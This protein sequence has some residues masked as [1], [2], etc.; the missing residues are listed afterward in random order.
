MIEQTAR[1]TRAQQR[2]WRPASGGTPAL[3]DHARGVI[4]IPAPADQGRRLV[5]E[6][7]A[8]L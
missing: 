7:T 8:D 3:R 2:P 4:E 5:V 1:L 6:W